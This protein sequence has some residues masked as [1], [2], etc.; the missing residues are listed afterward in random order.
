[1]SVLLS[2]EMTNVGNF[3]KD[4]YLVCSQLWNIYSAH[5]HP[6]SNICISDLWAF[7]ELGSNIKW[8]NMVNL[9]RRAPVGATHGIGNEMVISVEFDM[10]DDSP[11]I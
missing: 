5:Q 10:C 11:T 2:G 8:Q 7:R 3:S 1:M 6:S 9:A 4:F